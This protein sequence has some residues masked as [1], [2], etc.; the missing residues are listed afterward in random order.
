MWVRVVTTSILVISVRISSSANRGSQRL[1]AVLYRSESGDGLSLRDLC[2]DHILYK[3]ADLR[4]YLPSCMGVRAVTASVSVISVRISSSANMRISEVTCRPVW[5]WERWRP[6]SLW[7][8]WGSHPPRTRESQ[9]PPSRRSTRS[10][11]P[12]WIVKISLVY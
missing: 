8:L 7:S 9:N 6:P 11:R 4:G 10:F 2:E 3:Q 5:G 1:P 12:V